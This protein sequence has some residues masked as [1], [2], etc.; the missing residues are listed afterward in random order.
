MS[1]VFFIVS[2]VLFLQFLT[3]QK[4]ALD[5]FYGQG[6]YPN[7]LQYRGL[8]TFLARILSMN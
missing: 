1:C 4:K 3:N 7:D 5:Q 2:A 6:Q 8:G